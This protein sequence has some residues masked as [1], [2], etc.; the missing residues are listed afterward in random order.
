MEFIKGSEL[1]M[2]VNNLINEE[3]QV[4]ENSVD[5]TVGRVFNL[6]GKGIVDFGGSEHVIR[7][8]KEILSQ[9]KE[10]EDEY[11]WWHLTHGTYLIQF[12]ESL[13]LGDAVAVISPHVRLLNSGAHHVNRMV[14]GSMNAVEIHLIVGTQGID[15]KENARISILQG[16]R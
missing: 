11:G 1:K 10:A 3:I 12:N 14:S 7:P 13:D 8:Q 15:V 5:L 16:L 4:G 2:H 6:S 9:K